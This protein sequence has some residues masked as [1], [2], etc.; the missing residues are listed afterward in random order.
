M[1]EKYTSRVSSERAPPLPSPFLLPLSLYRC[2]RK[3]VVASPDTR[4]AFT[5]ATYRLYCSAVIGNEADE[6]FRGNSMVEW[7]PVR[8]SLVTIHSDE[9]QENICR[10]CRVQQAG[11]RQ[12]ATQAQ[13]NGYRVQGREMH[14][15]WLQTLRR[16]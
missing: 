15:L 3:G 7:L 14:D 4:V 16:S 9:R 1:G 11:G 2:F 8:H 6:I 10:P 13:A 5:H 12:T